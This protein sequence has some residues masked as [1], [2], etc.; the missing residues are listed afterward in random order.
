MSNELRKSII[1]PEVAARYQVA[2]AEDRSGIQ[3]DPPSQRTPKRSR[4]LNPADMIEEQMQACGHEIAGYVVYRTTYG[5]DAD[6]KQFLAR[7]NAALERVFNR[8]NGRDILDKF[9]LTIMED[10][11]LYNAASTD[12]IRQHLQ[13]WSA[14][15]YLSEQPHAKDPEDYA[16]RKAYGSSRYSTATLFASMRNPCTP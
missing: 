1:P 12:A 4:H 2:L 11:E 13:R 15:N 5:S 8:C 6:W 7:L 16:V 9:P 3:P 10:R 14:Q